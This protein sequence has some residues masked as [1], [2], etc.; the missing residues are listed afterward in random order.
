MKNILRISVFVLC[1]ICF[2]GCKSKEEKAAELI[3]NELSKSLYDFD[4]YKP[5]ETK[6]TVAKANLFNDT[7]CWNLGATLGYGMQQ[8][9]ESRER[10]DD[11]KDH[12]A[13][14]GAPSYYSSSYSDNQYY[15]YRSQYLEALS[16]A[17]A[18]ILVCQKIAEEIKDTLAN[19]DTT[20]VIGWEVFHD[21]RCKTRGGSPEIG[22]YRYIISKDFK[23]IILCEDREGT[24]DKRTREALETITTDYWDNMDSEE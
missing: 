21:F 18:G 6:V 2:V 23:S 7:T 1:A 24:D 22:H 9:V 20:L 11:A 15:K 16:E 4:S 19:I 10:M 14:W 13:I 5:I 8:V 17:T 12:M 3:K